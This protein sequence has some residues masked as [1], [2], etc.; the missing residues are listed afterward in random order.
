M[1]YYRIESNI[2]YSVSGILII[3]VFKSIHMPS[4][5]EH[6]LINIKYIDR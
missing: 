3:T 1:I 2:R 6:H 5:L 4:T